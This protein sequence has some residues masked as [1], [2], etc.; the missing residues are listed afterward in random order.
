MPTDPRH[1]HELRYAILQVLLTY[2][3]AAR[4]LQAIAR[5][6][7]P[8]YQG[9]TD[10]DVAAELA[11]LIQRRYV[12][13]RC[14]ANPYLPGVYE[15]LPAGRDQIELTAQTLDPAIHGPGIAGG[16]P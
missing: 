13:N 5:R 16:T 7:T 12:A 8:Y 11:D 4:S 2:G 6:V 9:A 14:A 1:A 15:L 3:A 10:Q